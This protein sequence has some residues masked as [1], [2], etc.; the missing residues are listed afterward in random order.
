[1]NDYITLSS[2]I[3]L[4]GIG[5]EL[6]VRGVVKLGRWARISPGIVAV[7]FA[8][9]ATSSPE[10]SVGINAA[11]ARAPQI[12]LGDALGSNVVNVGLILGLALVI[13]GMRATRTE[14]KRDFPVALIVPVII[15]VMTIDGL[16]S[17]IDG[18]ILLA[19]FTGWLIAVVLEARRQRN[20]AE[21][22]IEEHRHWLSIIFSTVGLG[23]LILA[24][25]LIVTGATGIAAAWG[26]GT[27]VVG[28]VIVAVGTSVPE[29]ATAV[30]AKIRGHD[31]I[32]LG[33]ILGSNIFNCLWIIGIVSIICPIVISFREV[34]M[35]L[36]FGIATVIL[37][38]PTRNGMISRWRGMV[39]L[40]L[41]IVYV[42]ITIKPA[43]HI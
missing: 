43:N 1:M 30:I 2:G 5:G 33:T 41:Y 3:V 31:E 16:V 28:A 7:T 18:I 6:F 4:A 34:A 14:V 9:F 42:L 27:F 15:G 22:V 19:I 32:G 17:R 12:S 21:K 23:L 35:A 38:Y 26:L 36:S 13:G 11:L 10:F 39:L 8:A 37:T 40:V 20:A 24:G 29:L 25:R